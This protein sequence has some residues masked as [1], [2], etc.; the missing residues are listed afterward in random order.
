MTTPTIRPYRDDDEG[1]VIALWHAAGVTRPWN[2]PA[3]DIARKKSVQRA[4]FLVIEDAGQVVASVMGGYDGHRGSLFY[5][6]V[7]PA[8]R[9]RGLARALVE[10]LERELTALGCPKVNLQVR[11]DNEQAIAFW[12]RLGYAPDRVVS[13][14]KRLVAPG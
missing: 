10:A 4:L 9:R 5:L 7:H 1:S 3:T 13:L 14:G 11:T 6:A 2:D 12:E 8:H